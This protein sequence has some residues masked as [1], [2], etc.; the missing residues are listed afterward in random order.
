MSNKHKTKWQVRGFPAAG[1]CGAQALIEM[2]GKEVLLQLAF[3]QRFTS[4][5][6]T[7]YLFDAIV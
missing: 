4:F 7:D 6:V 5:E 3:L 2:T 1:Q